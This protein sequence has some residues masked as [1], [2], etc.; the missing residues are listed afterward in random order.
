MRRTYISP[1]FKFQGVFGTLNMEEESSFF[2]SKMLEIED[3]IDLSDD[4]IV[5]YENDKN[6]QLDLQREFDFPVKIYNVLDDKVINHKLTLNAFQT[7]IEKL[8]YAKWDLNINIK[9]LLRNYF[10]STL[11]TNRTFEGVT[12]D[13][14]LNKNVDS[15]IKNYIERNVLNRYELQNVDLYL[16]PIDLLTNGAY[17]YKNVWDPT[18]KQ[19]QY[20]LTKFN[21]ETDINGNT[22]RIFFTQNFVA[23][24]YAFRYYFD[25]KYR[26]L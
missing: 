1:E 2:G 16:V 5:Y 19:E 24:Q 9:I 14:T 15:S 8:N 6:E 10:F 11:K 17:K 13:M 25:L 7:Q 20:K 26:K 12:N 4:V 18:I 23:S 3:S 21:T 22:L